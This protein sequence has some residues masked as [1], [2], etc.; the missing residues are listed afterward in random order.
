LLVDGKPAT[1]VGSDYQSPNT[2]ILNYGERST[3]FGNG[4]TPTSQSSVNPNL[5]SG[6]TAGTHQ[7]QSTYPGDNSFTGSQATYS[8]NITKED[9]FIADFFT[10]GSAVVNAPLNL[11]GQLGLVNN[12]C[13][14]YG[15]TV[16]ATDY[17][18]ATSVILGKA[19]ASQTYCDSYFV[20]VT[21]TTAGKHVIRMSFSGDSNVNASTATYV[22][23]VLAN[24]SS[25]TSLSV[26]LPT[27]APGSAVTLIAQV[28]SPV[29]LHSIAG[30]KV[31]FL[32]GS[33]LLGSATLGGTPVDLGGG[34]VGL[35]A[36]LI[37]STFSP[38]I[39]NLTA[40]YAGDS[41]LAASDSSS[42]PVTVT[43]SD[44]ALQVQ[45]ATL[46]V[47]AGQSGTATLSIIPLGGSTQ[48][49]QLS[50]GTLPTNISCSFAPTSV[51]LDGVNPSIVK[52][53][54]R[55]GLAIANVGKDLRGLGV[56][57]TLAFAGILLPFGG[58]KRRKSMWGLLTILATALC[59]VGCGGG[60]GN[61][62]VAQQGVYVVNVSASSG[63][64]SVTKVVPLVVT[65]TK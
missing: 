13:A 50:C 34:S 25:Y 10:D 64:G 42:S 59:V 38:G 24:E 63:T 32:D 31:T 44:Y 57:S 6:L 45:P 20:P 54:V 19:N 18:G 41:V 52:V 21:F 58:R 26:D 35:T 53:T 43:I 22:V 40:K 55:T 4:K 49:V 62:N 60:S 48:T 7:L 33:T 16:T 15:G 37:V 61:S 46:T 12:G 39:H 36:Q 29:R 47:Q 56:V 27:A 8:L 65:I 3:V 28:A 11:A 5:A 30:Q 2:L 51:T 17:S 14:P 1:A 23:N 9:S